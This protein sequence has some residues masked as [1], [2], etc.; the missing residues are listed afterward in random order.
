MAITRKLCGTPALRSVAVSPA[1]SDNLLMRSSNNAI[2]QASSFA[3][4]RTRLSATIS[5][6]RSCFWVIRFLLTLV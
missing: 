3:A 6:Y 5:K 1:Q 4:V 2:L